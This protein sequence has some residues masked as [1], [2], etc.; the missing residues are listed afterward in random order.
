MILTTLWSF[1]FGS[2]IKIAVWVGNRIATWTGLVV[3][4]KRLKGHPQRPKHFFLW[5]V[6]INGVSLALL[7]GLL[8]WLAHRSAH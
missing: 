8:W 5:L 4:W 2:P 7:V 6:V 3:M 1:V